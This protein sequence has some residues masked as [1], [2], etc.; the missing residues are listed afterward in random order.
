[1]INI[2]P[3]ANG[4]AKLKNHKQ[5]ATNAKCNQ[6]KI[7]GTKRTGEL[8]SILGGT[9]GRHVTRGKPL[10][11][12]NQNVLILKIGIQGTTLQLWNSLSPHFL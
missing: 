4:H 1:M 10:T 3:S 11:S 9:N 2:S 8:D 6:C 12:L 7:A 5:E